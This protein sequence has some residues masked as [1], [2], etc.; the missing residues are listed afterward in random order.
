MSNR[1]LDSGWF[2]V[3]NKLDSSIDWQEL[4]DWCH[5]EFGRYNYQIKPSRIVTGYDKDEII[6][7]SGNVDEEKLTAFKLRWL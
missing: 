7:I 6:Y 1:P 2:F 3:I 5:H 4:Q